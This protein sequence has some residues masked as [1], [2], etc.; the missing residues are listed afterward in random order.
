MKPYHLLTAGL[1]LT[2]CLA[3][4]ST[5]LESTTAMAGDTLKVS[6][7]DTINQWICSSS[8]KAFYPQSTATPLAQNIQ[9][10]IGE[11]TGGRYTGSLDNGQ[12]ML[13]NCAAQ[14]KKSC[15]E[16]LKDLPPLDRPSASARMMQEITL[17]PLYET[18]QLITYY[19]T[20]YQFTGGAHGMQTVAGTT[21]RKSDGRRFGWE[22]FR[23]DATQQ[24]RELVKKGLMTYFKVKTDNELQ[25]MLLDQNNMNY[26]PLPVTQPYMTKDGVKF[27]YQSY[28]IAPYA[29]GQPSFTLPYAQ[30]W[31][32]MTTA[33]QQMIKQE[34]GK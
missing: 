7:T 4:C 12:A 30:A 27:I 6:T 32:L 18:E 2:A 33:A 14:W 31:P 25:G 8:I 17:V 16:Q 19:A 26:L 29:A 23:S 28:E 11:Q 3:S 1:A 10:W 34:A 20:N 5:P 9:E 15:Q 24:L 21:F 13:D 22:M